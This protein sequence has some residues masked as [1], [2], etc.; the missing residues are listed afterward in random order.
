MK[1]LYGITKSNFGGAQRYVFELAQEAKRRKHDVAVLCGGPSFAEAS[2][3]KEG[4]LVS[5]LKEVGIRTILI[6][7]FSRDIDLVGDASRLLFIMKTVWREKPNVFHINSAKMSGAG[8]FTVFVLNLYSKLT[9]NSYKLEAIFTAHGWEFNAPRPQWQK[10]LIKFFSWLTVLGT[11][12]TICVSEKTKRNVVGLPFIK[13]KLIVV[14]N[15]VQ[16]FELKPREIA[17]KELGL[18]E[19]EFVVGAV[20][21]LHKVKGLDILLEA[22]GRFRKK[23]SGL[24]AIAGSGDE[25]ENLQNMAQTLGISDSVEFLGFVKDVR[26]LLFGFDVFAFPSRSEALPYAPLEAGLASLPVIASAVGGVPEIIESGI[27]GVL[28]PSEDP[29][30]VFSSLILLR[31]EPDLRIRLGAELNKTVKEK[32]SIK[33]MFEETFNLYE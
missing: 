29:D 25:L 6:P 1:I 4:I 14:R 7:G 10:I 9:A 28:V 13:S 26:C 32:F 18:P 30:A 8:I 23:Y 22:W 16:S 12:K 21:E 20:S 3:G 19:N 27:N 2:K 11:H 17:R 15:G 5:K 31:E 24:L 33:R